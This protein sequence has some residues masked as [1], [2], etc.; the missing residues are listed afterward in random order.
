MGKNKANLPSATGGLEEWQLGYWQI[1]GAKLVS[2]KISD[3]IVSDFKPNKYYFEIAKTLRI[4]TSYVQS[5]SAR[6]R[7]GMLKLI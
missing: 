4:R 6:P 3:K 5:A 7:K 1:L 2:D